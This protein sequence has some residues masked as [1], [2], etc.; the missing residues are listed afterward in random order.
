[1]DHLAAPGDGCKDGAAAPPLSPLLGDDRTGDTR[2]RG[3]LRQL[4]DGLMS[5][6]LVVNQVLLGFRSRTI[7]EFTIARPCRGH[8]HQYHHHRRPLPT[9][10]SKDK[11]VASEQLM[12]ELM[13]HSLAVR[14]VL[15]YTSGSG[16]SPAMLP[17]TCPCSGH[18]H[19]HRRHR[20]PM[21]TAMSKDERCH[22][23]VWTV[24]VM[25][26]RGHGRRLQSH[27]FTE[28]RMQHEPS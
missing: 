4:V 14:Q 6:W 8:R 3:S 24:D 21:P 2:T 7:S 25:Y 28:H 11:R 16:R 17:I 12:D 22:L 18:R 23:K 20:R 9:A 19:Q 5:H 15:P 27:P 13:S 10:L 26:F 1:M